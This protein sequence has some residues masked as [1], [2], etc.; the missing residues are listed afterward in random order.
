[1]TV[2]NFNSVDDYILSHPRETQDRVNNISQQIGKIDSDTIVAI[3]FYAKENAEGLFSALQ[4]QVASGEKIVIYLNAP[5]TGKYAI[6]ETDFANR[7][8]DLQRITAN[9]KR[10]V[11]AHHHYDDMQ[12][13]GT[14]R[15]DMVDA[16]ALSSK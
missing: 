7:L 2:K 11:I 6:S 3:P 16:I 1:M 14:I 15:S 12:T 13:I 9:D 5:K 4:A 8:K 10:F